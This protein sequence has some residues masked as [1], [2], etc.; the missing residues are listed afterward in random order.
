MTENRIDFV[1]TGVE[2]FEFILEKGMTNNEIEL[3]T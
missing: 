3:T 2:K 1:F